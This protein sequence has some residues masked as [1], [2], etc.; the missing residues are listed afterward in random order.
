ME[1]RICFFGHLCVCVGLSLKKL[2]YPR[3]G[4]ALLHSYSSSRLI[5]WVHK[6]LFTHLEVQV[7]MWIPYCLGLGSTVRLRI[8][9]ERG[10]CVRLESMGVRCLA[11]EEDHLG[12]VDS[13][14]RKDHTKERKLPCVILWALLTTKSSLVCGLVS[15][16]TSISIIL[17][18][19][20][21]IF[22]FFWYPETFLNVLGLMSLV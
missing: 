18:I 8:S 2:Y 21:G 4:A 20:F 16:L 14:G 22:F 5:P 13:K 11:S 7:L 1:K 12:E 10:L 6:K 19:N 9:S 17:S 15:L 3:F